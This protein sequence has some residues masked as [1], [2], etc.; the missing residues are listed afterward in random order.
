MPKTTSLARGPMKTCRFLLSGVVLLGACKSTQSREA[1]LSDDQ[2]AVETKFDVLDTAFLL[3]F[4]DERFS[5]KASGALMS[6]EVFQ[7]LPPAFFEHLGR[8]TTW[9]SALDR[10]YITGFRYDPC[11][12]M[13][14]PDLNS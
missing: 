1:R 6:P 7:R 14:T 9:E 5:I 12:P 11:F 10:L 13:V 4:P 8:G 2:T 3:P